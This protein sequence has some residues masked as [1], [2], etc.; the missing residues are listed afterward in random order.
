LTFSIIAAIIII[1][2]EKEVSM[3]KTTIQIS[4]ETKERL[5]KLGIKGDTYDA[6]ICRLLDKLGKKAV[7]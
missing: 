7:K 2:G 6:I 1:E 5:S 4:A 3:S